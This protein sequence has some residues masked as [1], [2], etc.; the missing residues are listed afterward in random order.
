M[1][2]NRVSWFRYNVCCSSNIVQISCRTRLEFRMWL[3]VDWSTIWQRASHLHVIGN[4][5]IFNDFRPHHARI[6]S[7][8][9]VEPSSPTGSSGNTFIPAGHD[10]IIPHPLLKPFWCA[11]RT[12][13]APGTAASRGSFSAQLIAV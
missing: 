10:R 7:N 6:K 2:W 11:A 1:R 8:R 5:M 13:T 3:N 4:K 12:E 9:R